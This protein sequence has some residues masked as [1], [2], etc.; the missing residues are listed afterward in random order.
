VTLVYRR[1]REHMSAT[2]HEQHLAQTEG[3]LIRDWAQ[4][5]AIHAADG[6]VIGVEFESTGLDAQGA[7]TGLGATFTVPADQ[8]FKAIGQAFVPTPFE[9]SEAPALAHR[10]IA[11]DESRRT[12]LPG[13]WAGGDCVPGRDLTVVSVE[14]G[15]RAARSIHEFLMD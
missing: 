11:V 10:R 15:K 1:G 7:L 4:P 9:G 12:S 13:V 2:G 5:V 8:V 3:V 14:D 6:A